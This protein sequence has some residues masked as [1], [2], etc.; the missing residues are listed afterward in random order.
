[1]AKYSG[2]GNFDTGAGNS[3]Q[4][5]QNFS[6]AFTAPAAGAVTLTEGYANPTDPFNPATVTVNSLPVSGFSDSLQ[7]TCAVTA[8]V[9]ANASKVTAPTCTPSPTTLAGDGGTALSYTLAAPS[10]VNIGSYSIVLTAQD[11]LNTAL[12]HVSAPLTVYVVGT[13]AGLNLTPGVIGTETV[14]FNTAAAASGDSLTGFKC[15]SIVEVVGGVLQAPKASTNLNCKG[16]SAAVSVTGGS[17][18][19]PISISTTTNTAQLQRSGT[20]YAATLL[21]MPLLALLG[22]MG[23]VRSARRNLFRISGLILLLVIAGYA[24]ACGGSFTPPA[25]PPT[26][27]FPTGSYYVQVVATDSAGAT[28]YAVVPLTVNAN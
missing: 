25:T 22:W 19:V 26:S 3:S 28:Y 24:T 14:D 17:T 10:G 7:V 12:T 18:A 1:M 4:T 15:G 6:V 2:D 11:T 13:S 16:P 8:V 27:A 20:I 5:V 21:G 9:V 23:S